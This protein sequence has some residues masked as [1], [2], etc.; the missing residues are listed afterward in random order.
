LRTWRRGYALLNRDLPTARP[1]AVLER[2]VGGLL[3]DSIVITEAVADGH[4]LDTMLRLYLAPHP[5]DLQRRVKNHIAIRLAALLRQMHERGFVHRDLKASNL[6]VQWN[7]Y[8]RD[9]A[10]LAL[11][12]L[13][14]L[15]LRRR[16]RWQDELDAL[17]RLN[18]SLDLCTTVTLTDRVRFL[19]AYLR[20]P[21]RTD[22]QWKAT[23]YRLQE[24]SARKRQHK[25]K[26]LQW[27]L[28]HYGR[29]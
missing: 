1:L 24:L 13:D 28:E 22:H 12:D 19:K 6:L 4:D 25:A 11:V 5:P 3:L 7:P 23:W 17:V 10:G 9:A 16:V 18:V 29:P 26:R 2:R 14:G 27:K 20:R 15:S 8:Q 21:G